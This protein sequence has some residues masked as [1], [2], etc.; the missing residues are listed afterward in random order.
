M[1]HFTGIVGAHVNNS[2][3]PGAVAAPRPA[4]PHC[5]APSYCLVVVSAKPRSVDG[6]KALQ[7]ATAKLLAKHEAGLLPLGMASKR[8][9]ME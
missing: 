9:T 2:C 8:T 3:D 5:C 7:W 1:K 6:H 4:R